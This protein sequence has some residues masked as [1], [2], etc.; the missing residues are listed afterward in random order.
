MSLAVCVSSGIARRD[1]VGEYYAL[2][3]TA[4]GGMVFFVAPANL[5]TL[6]LGLEWFSIALYILCALDTTGDVARGR[7]QVPDRRQ[8]RL[9]DAA[10]R[11]RA[12]LRLDRRARLRKIAARRARRDDAL[13]S[14][15]SR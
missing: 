2:L 8:L 6:F 4:G 7:A 14:R 10:L 5:M 15:A 11:L 12:R 3:A 13:S 9:G 1:H